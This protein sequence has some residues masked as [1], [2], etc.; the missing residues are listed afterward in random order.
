MNLRLGDKVEKLIEKTVPK[1]IIHYVKKD[2]NCGCAKRKAA[3]NKLDDI[4]K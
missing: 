1:S 3:L 2:G 4:F